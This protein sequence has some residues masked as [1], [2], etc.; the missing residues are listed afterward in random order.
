MKTLI[1]RH[2]LGLRC[3]PMSHK[4]DALHIR[5]RGRPVKLWGLTLK[6]YYIIQSETLG[7]WAG[8]QWLSGR[9]LDSRQRAAG[10]SLTG[11]TAFCP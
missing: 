4:M 9:R 1:R 5:F 3:L 10:S 11:V 8:A 6:V 7:S 2:D